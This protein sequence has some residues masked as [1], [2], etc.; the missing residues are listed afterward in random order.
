M[1]LMEQRTKRDPYQLVNTQLGRY[2]ILEYVGSGGMG[3]VYRARHEIYKGD[4]AVKVLKPDLTTEYPEMV[5]FFFAEAEKT[6]GLDHPHIISVKYADITPEGL[7]FLVMEWLDGW[8]LEEEMREVGKMSLERIATLLEQIC[9]AVAYAHGHGIIHRDLKPSNVMIVTDYQGQDAAKILDFGIAK[10]LNSTFGANSRVMGSPYYASPEQLTLDSYIDHRS[11]I[12]SLG[13]L[14]YEALAGK[15]PFDGDS[16]G[17]IIQQ[18]LSVPPPSILERRPDLPDAVADVIQRALAKRPQDRF[19]SATDLA[20]AFRQAAC[21]DP[22][23]L[24]IRC[25][26]APTGFPVVGASVYLNGEY[27]G[28]TDDHG[29][30]QT[31]SAPPRE[32]LLEVECSQYLGWERHLHISPSSTFIQTVELTPKVVG[33]LTIRTSVAGAEVMINGQSAGLTNDTGLLHL[34]DLAEGNVTVEIRHP[35]HAPMVAEIEIKQGQPLRWDVA[36]PPLPRTRQYALAGLFGVAAIALAILLARLLSS[37]SSPKMNE[38]ELVVPT[39]VRPSLTQDTPIPT[40][41]TPP[42]TAK[43]MQ[44][45]AVPPSITP[46]LKPSLKEN[47]APAVVRGT[48]K[49]TVYEGKNSYKDYVFELKQDGN[50]VSGFLK[51]NKNGESYVVTGNV[52]GNHVQLTTHIPPLPATDTFIGK[53][54]DD[55]MEGDL[56]VGP[57]NN[58]RDKRTWLA[59]RK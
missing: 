12:Y 16:I 41:P 17:K 49:L 22:G 27:A 57:N 47:P 14:L 15:V 23:G 29:Q 40:T 10:A 36:L 20:R 19:G 25:L 35:R 59:L 48:W 50:R 51:G 45:G 3:A 52:K 24:T 2:Q 9:Q 31:K 37:G 7:A 30:W 26:D 32:H 56:S 46:T 34:A 5:G 39:P 6:V 18:H 4:V 53:V 54:K 11:D 33:E 21:L 38:K 42:L 55:R 44:G 43:E 28:R 8:T 1:T 13:I 58:L